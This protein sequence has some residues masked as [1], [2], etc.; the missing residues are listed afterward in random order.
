MIPESVSDDFLIERLLDRWMVVQITLGS[1]IV[2]NYG[3]SKYFFSGTLSSYE[4][5]HCP[6]KESIKRHVQPIYLCSLF[7]IYTA[8]LLTTKYINITIKQVIQVSIDNDSGKFKGNV[9]K[10]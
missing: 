6:R 2:T 7:F 4:S 1:S 5:V 10:L 3:S 8:I 9:N